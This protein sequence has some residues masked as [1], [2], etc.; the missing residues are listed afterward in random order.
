MC[1]ITDFTINDSANAPK[2]ITRIKKVNTVEKVPDT[3][4]DIGID[5][6]DV[7]EET[8]PDG[9]KKLVYK[10]KRSQCSLKSENIDNQQGVVY[11]EIVWYLISQF[12]N[13]EDVGYFACINKTT[14]AITKCG[15]FWRGLYSRFCENN[16]KLPE[17]LIIGKNFRV[18]GLRQRVIRALYHTYDVFINKV[19]QQTIYDSHPHNL[20]KC[21]CVNVWFCKG[22]NYWT[23]FFKLKKSQLF[24]RVETVDV[25]EEL[26]RIDANP[27]ENTQVLKVG[28]QLYCYFFM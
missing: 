12:I 13:P 16:R 5:E 23:V 26:G 22:T 6:F 18:Y 24:K 7:I 1:V 27:E 2:P 25:I 15:S 8:A 17:T 9:S 19:S 10:K 11:P 20:V 28:I 21:R 4:D 3:W 14:Y